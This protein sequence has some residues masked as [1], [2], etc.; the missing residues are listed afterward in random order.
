MPTKYKYHKRKGKVRIGIPELSKKQ[1]KGVRKVA[2]QVL[3]KTMEVKVAG[4]DGENVQLFHNKPF[5]QG[6]MLYTQQGVQDNEDLQANA[7]RIGDEILLR[8]VNLRLWLSNKLD[9][10]N[11]MYKCILFWYRE[12]V[13]LSDAY[14]FFTQKNKMLDR[15]NT[16]NISIIDQK[17]V[18]SKEMYLNGTEKF[19]HSQLCTLNGNWKGK[20]IKYADGS[21]QPSDKNIGWCI[22]CYDAFGTLQTDNIA[23]FAF[24]F[25]TRFQD[26]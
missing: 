9:R 15:L 10:P 6:N 23:S 4:A 19:E 16:E 2:R 13:S 7:S 17:T 8:N 26:P 21:T 25:N 1:E 22:V 3:R 18:F 5:Y 24:N 14:V 12:G 11:V 20:K